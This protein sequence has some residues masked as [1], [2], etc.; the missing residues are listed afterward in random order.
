MLYGKTTERFHQESITLWPGYL[1]TGRNHEFVPRALMSI[2]HVSMLS[3]D[4]EI[5]KL[6]MYMVQLELF[7]IE[8][9]AGL[10]FFATFWHKQYCTH[11]WCL[12]NH[13]HHVTKW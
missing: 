9:F 4:N 13:H 7:D 8:L 10:G 1:I 3:T 5:T 6:N 11:V 2:V 12:L